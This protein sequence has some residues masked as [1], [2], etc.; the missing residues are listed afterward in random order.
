VSKLRRKWLE[1]EWDNEGVVR[2]EDIPYSSS[3]SIKEKIDSL[4]ASGGASYIHVQST[5][6]NIWTVD[7]SLNQRF[8]NV[9][10]IGYD[11]RAIIPGEI[12]Y[13]DANTL[14]ISFGSKNLTGYA[15]LIKGSGTSGTSGTSGVNWT[16]GI[17]S[18]RPVSPVPYQQFFDATLGKP[19]WWNGS[20][21]V[22]SV[23]N[24]V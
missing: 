21:W 14:T 4:I 11:Y 13:T 7:H 2:A 6:A 10:V 12:S 8:V 24:I 18:N 3:M 9:Q 5:P 15:V 20:N 16:G 22:D 1:L 23:G 19:I 17:T